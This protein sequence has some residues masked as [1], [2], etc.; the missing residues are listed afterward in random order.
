MQFLSFCIV[1]KDTEPFQFNSQSLRCNI[2][3]TVICKTKFSCSGSFLKV[4]A[5]ALVLQLL[6][7]GAWVIFEVQ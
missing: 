1:Q 7:Y 6:V 5:D 2:S 4:L 3:P